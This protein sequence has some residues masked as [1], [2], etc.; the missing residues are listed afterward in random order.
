MRPRRVSHAG[1]GAGSSGRP[2]VPPP[3]HK[4]TRTSGRSRGRLSR[5]VADTVC[6]DKVH[7][8][9]VIISQ[10]RPRTR[11]R[12]SSLDSCILTMVAQGISS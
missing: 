12:H 10:P 6:R 4:R 5:D 8:V 9:Q 7:L 2:V 11:E 1:C 3:A